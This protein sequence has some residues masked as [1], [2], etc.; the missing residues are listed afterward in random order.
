MFCSEWPTSPHRSIDTN[1]V[2]FGTVAIVSCEDGFM[3]NNDRR[4]R[5]TAECVADD[6]LTPVAFWNISS[7]QLLCQR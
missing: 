3:F 4:V 5:V 2:I 7:A 6:T 1:E